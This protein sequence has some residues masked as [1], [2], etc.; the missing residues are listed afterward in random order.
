MKFKPFTLIL[1][2]IIIFW[3]YFYNS[4]SNF[5]TKTIIEKEKEI[6]I[7]SWE[8]LNW[9]WKKLWLTSFTDKYTYK[10]YIKFNTP[11]NFKLQAWDYILR[12]NYTIKNI[13]EALWKPI[14]N[15]Q[16]ITIL[17]WWNIYDIDNY[18]SETKWLIKS[19]TFIE[20][21]ENFDKKLI[22]KYPFLSNVK[23]L[24]WFLYPDS[25]DINPNNFSN[26]ILINKMLS[27]FN[28]KVYKKYLEN[29]DNKK[30]VE[31]INLASIVEKEANS[32][33]NPEEVA[34]IAGILK[35]RLDENWAVWADATACYPYKITHKECTPSFIWQHINE[36][37]AYNLRKNTWLP[38][39]PIG[40]P[41]AK[42][43]K[44][45]VFYT[46]TKHYFYLHDSDWKIHYAVTNAEHELNKSKFIY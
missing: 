14:T 36:E 2:I 44:A 17:E 29:Y 5:E 46:K 42:T 23:T 8:T 35:K 16:Q 7:E 1:W 28:T 32:K 31:T 9:L 10:F 15:D 6:K 43:I 26:E 12:T 37:N 22:E 21:T 30:I 11:A 25:Y 33:D 34:I 38:P 40:N 41:S 27:T 24:E 13:F 19:W 39:T 45:T 20:K 18:L 3:F 4:Y